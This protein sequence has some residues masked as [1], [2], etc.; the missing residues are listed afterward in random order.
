MSNTRASVRKDR[1]YRCLWLPV[2]W[3]V[4]CIASLAHLFLPLLFSIYV[5]C[6][7]EDDQDLHI[8]ANEVHQFKWLCLLIGVCFVSR[9]L[10]LL[11]AWTWV[12]VRPRSTSSCAIASSDPR[13]GHGRPSSLPVSTSTI[14]RT[15]TVGPSHPSSSQALK[16]WG[17]DL[18]DI[19]IPMSVVA[20]TSQPI[21]QP[22]YDDSVEEIV[23]E[24]PARRPGSRRHKT[25]MTGYL[26]I[27]FEAVDEDTTDSPGMDFVSGA[28]PSREGRRL[29]EASTIQRPPKSTSRRN[30]IAGASPSSQSRDEDTTD[31]PGMDFVSGA[32]PSR[33]GRRL[34]EVST[35]Q[36]PPKFASRQ[37]LI[38]GAGPSSQSRDEES[39]DEESS[40]SLSFYDLPQDSPYD[41][42]YDRVAFEAVL[43]SWNINKWERANIKLR[44]DDEYIRIPSIETVH[45]RQK[46]FESL[47][48]SNI[49]QNVHHPYRPIP[50]FGTAHYYWGD[51]LKIWVNFEVYER[52]D[53]F[54]PQGYR[55]LSSEA[56]L[57][58][59]KVTTKGD[60]PE[61][62]SLARA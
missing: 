56:E 31:S 47:V 57:E 55:C 6:S 36:R 60:S 41:S 62:N 32:M 61:D 25:R 51:M 9:L 50:I 18:S 48:L 3:H 22:S 49:H 15:P 26:E 58:G 46:S 17:S 27:M 33:E 14:I 30:L 12:E 20:E 10:S 28:M 1:L 24:D 5:L 7:G 45:H 13:A 39:K 54:W 19:Q 23:R 2:L 52:M 29:V 16:P 8:W 59:Y 38:A 43:K 21:D 4:L 53:S 11:V 44:C 34:A 42:P 37:N 35:I 40:V